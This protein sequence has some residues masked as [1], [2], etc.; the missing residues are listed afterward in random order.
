MALFN[1]TV[2]K[3]TSN[4]I[5]TTNGSSPITSPEGAMC[6][7]AKGT[8]IEGKITTSENMRI[9]GTVRGEVHCEKRLV[10]DASGLIEGNVH[11]GEST[12]KGKV[13]G[14]VSVANTLHLLESSF[15]K[16]DIKAKKLHV[17]EGA[18]YDGKCLIG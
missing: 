15:I 14:T 16:G 10:M 4:G 17:E 13:V 6:V 9:D 7:I 2:E 11:A 1:G 18:K 12:I 5:A 3:K 8:I